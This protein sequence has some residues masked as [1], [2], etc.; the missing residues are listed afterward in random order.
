MKIKLLKL[1]DRLAGGVVTACLPS[2]PVRPLPHLWRF[3]LIRPGG[4][5]DAVL[6]ASSICSIKKTCPDSHITILAE[7]RNCGVFPLIPQA[8]EVLCYDRPGELIKALIGKYDIVIDTE[9]WYRLSA[10]VAR[11][12]RAPVKIGFDTN[13]RRRMFTRGI[14]YDLE[15]YEADNFFALLKP[16]GVDSYQDI[17][18]V[19]LSLPLQ[20]VTE[21]HQLLQPLFSDSFVVIFPGASVEE[22]RWGSARFLKV[23]KKLAEYGYRIVI[24]GGREDRTNGDFIAVAGGIN[25]AGMTT[26]AETAAVI[27]RSSLV[28]SG[29]SGLLHIAAGLDIPTV[30]LFGP[31]SDKKWAPQ[32]KKHVVINH[33]LSCSPC[34]RFGTIPPCP[35]GVCCIRDITPD[36]VIDAAR[37]L[38]PQLPE[39]K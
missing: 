2:V 22:K 36:E 18:A 34:S 6:L 30:S 11:L 16:L 8:D 4:V 7:S 12:V 35:V 3:L 25:L 28:I 9:Q 14:R 10:V 13:E 19:T 21:A 15:A 31:S 23:S 39:K 38:L 24:V 27:V 20:S 37:R 1:I 33:Y 29:D 5:G 17:E 32:G 26:L